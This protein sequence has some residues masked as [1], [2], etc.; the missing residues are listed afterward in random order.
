MPIIVVA[1]LL[2]LYVC[3]MAVILGTEADSFGQWCWM[4]ILLLVAMALSALL[5]GLFYAQPHA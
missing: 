3:W 1:I 4:M 2:A 5:G